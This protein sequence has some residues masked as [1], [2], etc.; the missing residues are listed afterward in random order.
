MTRPTRPSNSS[1]TINNGGDLVDQAI[2]WLSEFGIWCA[3]VL[4]LLLV[5]AYGLKKLKQK[6]QA[7]QKLWVFTLF[8]LTKRQMMI[9]LVVSLSRNDKILDKKTQKKLM[10]IREKC[11]EVSFKT[12]PNA[13]LKLEQEVSEILLE[14]FT[15]LEKKSQIK[16]G[17]K[18]HKIVQDLEF[19]DHK[20][21][22]LQQVYNRETETWNKKLSLPGLQTILKPLGIKTF[23]KFH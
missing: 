9:P 21:V 5:L 18:F 17:S 8:F 7:I 23:E 22:Q 6:H 2:F 12:S 1:E 15:K 20:L 3:I 14:Y 4:V 16:S 19:I 11:R 13:R 10:E